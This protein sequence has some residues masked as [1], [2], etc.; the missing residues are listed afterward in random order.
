M[1]GGGEVGGV[2]GPGFFGVEAECSYDA[3]AVTGDEGAGE[4]GITHVDDDGAF[5]RRGGPEAVAVARGEVFG[6]RAMEVSELRGVGF[7]GGG[8]FEFHV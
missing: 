7:G 5:G 1:R 6:D 2:D 8:E 4:F 3:S